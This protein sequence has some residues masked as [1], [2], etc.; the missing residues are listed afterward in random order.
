L[1]AG[2]DAGDR[3]RPLPRPRG[4]HRHQRLRRSL[5]AG[6]RALG[7]L[8]AAD[9][10]SRGAL[11]DGADDLLLRRGSRGLAVAGAGGRG[12]AGVTRDGRPPLTRYNTRAHL[13][14]FNWT[15]SFA[16]TKTWRAAPTT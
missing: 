3:E 4:E 10:D 16:G 6:A 11:P 8:R 9:V 13:W 1:G 14:P 7:P 5:R 2:L 12:A 15:N